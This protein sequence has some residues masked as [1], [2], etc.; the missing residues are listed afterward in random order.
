M[1]FFVETKSKTTAKASKENVPVK[2]KSQ[3]SKSDSTEMFIPSLAQKNKQ[4]KSKFCNVLNNKPDQNFDIFEE[5][6]HF[7]R[8]IGSSFTLST[9]NFEKNTNR[10]NVQVNIDCLLLLG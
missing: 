8:N 1:A 3:K 9:I 5:R 6:G 7:N 4:Y 10:N 2:N